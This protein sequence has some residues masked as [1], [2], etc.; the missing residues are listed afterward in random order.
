MKSFTFLMHNIYALGGTVKAITELA[1]GISLALK[2][3]IISTLWPL[4]AKVFANSV[5]ALTVPPKA[6]ILLADKGHNVE[7]ISIFRAKDM[8]YFKLNSSIKIRRI[9]LNQAHVLKGR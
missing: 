3:E 9:D 2:I 4:S 1:N 5:I 7:I 6:Y 8:P